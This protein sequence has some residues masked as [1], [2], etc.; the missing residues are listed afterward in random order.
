M[1]TYRRLLGIFYRSALMNELEYRLNFWSLLLMQLFWMV[2]S[3]VGIRVPFLYVDAIAGWTYPELLL[4]VGMF[5]IMRG[6][7]EIILVPNLWQMTEYVRMGTLD[8]ILTKPINSQFMVS[9]RHL[10]L[11]SWAAPLLGLGLIGYGLW[12]VGSLPSVLDLLAFVVLTLAGMLVL[13]SLNLAI[14][15]LTFWV[16]DLEATNGLVQSVT[17]AGRFPVAFYS[18]WLRIVLTYIVPVALLTTFP[19]QALLGRSPGWLP[20][21]SVG[22]A[23]LSFFLASAFWRLA[24][25][26]YTSASS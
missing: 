23:L 17:E 9:L 11:T 18:G 1:R 22:V 26:S 14:Q 2:W 16:V 15:S 21:L 25:R 7:M 19:A 5:T 12:G 13:Y 20:P 4:V 6:F 10:G 8:F 3:A 24:L